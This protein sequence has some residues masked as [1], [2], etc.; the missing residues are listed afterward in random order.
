M[1][2]IE[3]DY[4]YIYAGRNYL[5]YRIESDKII[6]AEMFDEREDFM[7]KLFGITTTTQESLDYWDEQGVKIY[8][9]QDLKNIHKEGLIMANQTE[10]L[11]VSD[12]MKLE[13][14]RQNLCEELSSGELCSSSSD[15]AEE[16]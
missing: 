3:C 14:D 6:I 10:L 12:E 2:G 13:N 9:S 16:L 15:T 8:R 7:Y 5:F 4:R 1:Y 11:N